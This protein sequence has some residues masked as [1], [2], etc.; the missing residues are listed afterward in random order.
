MVRRLQDEG[1]RMDERVST[2]TS[3]E[4]HLTDV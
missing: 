1:R 2:V 3:N 4:S